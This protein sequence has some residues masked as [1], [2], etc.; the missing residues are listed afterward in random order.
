MPDTDTSTTVSTPDLSPLPSIYATFRRVASYLESVRPPVV[1]TTADLLRPTCPYFLLYESSNYCS[2]LIGVAIGGDPIDW[3]EWYRAEPTARLVTL[4]HLPELLTRI[5]SAT[6]ALARLAEPEAIE[7][8]LRS[9]DAA[10]A[11]ARGERQ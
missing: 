8:A 5:G 7:K 11:I 4:A 2:I 10:L 6:A 9:V 3:F 1:I